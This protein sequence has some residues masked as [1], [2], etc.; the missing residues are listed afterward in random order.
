M[1][2]VSPATIDILGRVSRFR[3][4]RIPAFQTDAFGVVGTIVLVAQ[5]KLEA[6]FLDPILG[7]EHDSPPIPLLVDAFG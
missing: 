1:M 2:I 7:H 6:V 4:T 3:H 5:D